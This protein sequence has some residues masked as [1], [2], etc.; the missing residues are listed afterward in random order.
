MHARPGHPQQKGMRF[1]ADD[2]DLFGLEDLLQVTS[3]LL[4][5]RLHAGRSMM[6]ALL[7]SKSVRGLTTRWH[8]RCA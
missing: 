7:S 4:M 5:C 6:W 2:E 1:F 3:C 8:R